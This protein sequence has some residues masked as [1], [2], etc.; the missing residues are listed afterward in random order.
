MSQPAVMSYPM[1]YSVFRAVETAGSYHE[2][3]VTD[4]GPECV[5][6]EAFT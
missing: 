2:A 4:G 3:I 6:I 5:L 1:D